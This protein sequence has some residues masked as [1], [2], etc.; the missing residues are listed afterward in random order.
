MINPMKYVLSSYFIPYIHHGF[1]GSVEN[2]RGRDVENQPFR[3]TKTC[4][5]CHLLLVGWLFS[6]AKKLFRISF[7]LSSWG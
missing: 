4:Q 2:I 3:F 6:I 7:Y 1:W 5:T